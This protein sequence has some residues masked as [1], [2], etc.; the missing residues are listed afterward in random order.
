MI[1][2]GRSSPQRRDLGAER[3][4][5][6]EET[7]ANCGLLLA[8]ADMYCGHCGQ[9]KL[10]AATAAAPAGAGWPDSGGGSV[11]AD[12]VVRQRTPNPGRQWADGEGVAEQAPSV[13][14]SESAVRH[15]DATAFQQ[16]PAKT[17]VYKNPILYGF[18]GV[19]FPP[20]V[21]SLMGGD[22]KTCIIMLCIW[23]ISFLLLFLLFIGV[24]PLVGLYFWSIVACYREAVK[25]NEAHGLS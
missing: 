6:M 24:I 20:L 16:P 4:G 22:R 5:S 8:T 3:D 14:P 15:R 7:C 12:A 21:L 2:R 13:A 1:P 10:T 19:F 9:P 11:P 23:P 18:G 17:Y 25:Q